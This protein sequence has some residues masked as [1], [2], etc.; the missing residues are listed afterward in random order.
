[1]PLTR[2]FALVLLLGAGALM[3]C[4]RSTPGDDGAVVDVDA[5]SAI[6]RGAAAELRATGDGRA[7]EY[8][9]VCMQAAEHDNRPYVL[10]K[11]LEDPGVPREMGHYHGDFKVKGHHWV[12][13]RRVK[14]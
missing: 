4:A 10:S 7:Y 13:E 8:R 11:W 14:R 1:M 2:R 12:L 9:A 6:V 3:G 5:D